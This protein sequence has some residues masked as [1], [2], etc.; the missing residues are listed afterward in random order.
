MQVV[1]MNVDD[2]ATQYSYAFDCAHGVSDRFFACA[3]FEAASGRGGPNDDFRV[4]KITLG[5]ATDSAHI[6]VQSDQ[7]VVDYLVM[8]QE[9]EITVEV[10]RLGNQ[11]YW[12]LCHGHDR[13]CSPDWLRYRIL[14][15]DDG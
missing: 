1:G 11:F 14:Q 10:Q 13:D 9:I 2:N 7:S 6:W 8:G 12:S 3:G 5:N 15:L 4:T